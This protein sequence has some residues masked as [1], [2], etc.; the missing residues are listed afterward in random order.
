V[1]RPPSQGWPDRSWDRLGFLA[2]EPERLHME[3]LAHEGL[4]TTVARF[5]D[6]P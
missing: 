4:A 1:V 3:V 5:L 6:A 2:L